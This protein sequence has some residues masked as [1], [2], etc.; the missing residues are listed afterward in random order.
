MNEEI[1]QKI[2]YNAVSVYLLLFISWLLLFNKDKNVNNSFVKSHIKSS[3]IIDILIILNYLIFIHFR[4]LQNISL[5]STSLNIVLAQIWFLAI[6]MLLVKWVYSALN[7]KEQKIGNSI[8]FIKWVSLDINNDQIVNEKD[9]LTILI[10]YI[11]FVSY[12]IS[13]KFLNEKIQNI[14]KFN[15]ISS[16][17]VSFVY[18]SWYSN[19]VSLLSLSYIIFSCFAITYLYGKNELISI[20]LPDYILPHILVRNIKNGLK[21]VYKYLKWDFKEYKIIEAEEQEKKAKIDLE[22][23]NLLQN[24]PDSKLPKKLIYVPVINFLFLFFGK[25]KYLFHIRNWITLSFVFIVFL[26][27]IYFNMVSVRWIIMFLFPITFWEWILYK[28]YYKMPFIY[29][30]Y[31]FFVWVKR[32]FHIWRQKV[33]ENSVV[34]EVNLKVGEQEVKKE[35]IV[36]ETNLKIWENEVKKTET[37]GQ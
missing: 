3:I 32:L 11:P 9:K 29:E 8:N 25:N 26:I 19:V 5:F 37:Q 6:W 17:F 13:S 35:S 23:Q 4:F 36:Q 22:E 14:L 7:S 31:E 28:Q 30:I 20:N 12:I 34:Q 16:L 27:L 15:L 21:Y 18:V 10:S 2:R 1:N 33:K 24:L